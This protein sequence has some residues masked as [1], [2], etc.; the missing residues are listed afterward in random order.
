[1]TNLFDTA[2][3]TGFSIENTSGSPIALTAGGKDILPGETKTLDELSIGFCEF[4]KR[5]LTT[6]GVRAYF[7]DGGPLTATAITSPGAGTVCPGDNQDPSNDM[8]K[9]DE[10]DTSRRYLKDSVRSTDA[11]LAITS[12]SKDSDKTLVFEYKNRPASGLR[13]TEDWDTYATTGSTGF[14][15]AA[16]GTAAAVAI[17]A[18]VAVDATHPGVVELDTGTDTTGAAA[19]HKGLTS[20]LLGGGI[21]TVE[22]LV[23]IATLSDGTETHAFR[24]GVGDS[25]TADFVDGVYFEA[26]NNADGQWQLKSASNSTRTTVDSAVNITTAWTKLR[27]E[28]NPA[29]V[30]TG[31]VTNTAGGTTVTGVGTKFTQEYSVGQYI[32]IGAD[33]NKITAITSN[34]VMTTTAITNAHATATAHTIT[35]HAKFFIDGT[36]VPETIVTNFP[37]GA[38]RFCGPIVSLVKSAGTTARKAY[39]DY[40]DFD[41][42]LTTNR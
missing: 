10:N 21:L 34:T 24:L 4:K 27:L 31:T 41:L 19:V 23:K 42:A 12:V 39:V 25:A 33:T 1:M 38:G 29:V 6:S 3:L 7:D 32:T 18:S 2:D 35:Q 17:D 20:I 13:F 9:V 40:Y 30:G 14:N 36:R 26:D 16:T 22:A 15:P 11:R 37:T 8:I 5:Y 28:Y